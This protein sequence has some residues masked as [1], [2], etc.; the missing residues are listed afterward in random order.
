VRLGPARSRLEHERL[1]GEHRELKTRVAGEP[2]T[3]RQ[4]SLGLQAELS[5]VTPPE[6]LGTTAG[7]FQTARFVGAGL[8]AGLLGVMVAD[9]PTTD[10]LYQLW[11]VTGS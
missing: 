8:A 6:R 9:I 10:R 7:F 1:P 2:V 4:G 11:I 5:E 3:G